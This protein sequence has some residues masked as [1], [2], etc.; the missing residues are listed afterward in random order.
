MD[1]VELSSSHAGVIGTG[2]DAYTEK[3][4]ICDVS[5]TKALIA[6]GFR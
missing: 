1:R 6:G 5:G 3:G 4:V 2:R